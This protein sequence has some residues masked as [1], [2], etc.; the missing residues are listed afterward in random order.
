MRVLVSG[1]GGQLG[2]ELLELLSGSEHEAVGLTRR[3]LDISD[4][5]AVY[6]AVR[7]HSPGLIVNAAAFTDVDGCETERKLAYRVNALGPR[8]LAQVGE[9]SGCEL[10]HV[11]T[12]YVFSGEQAEPYEVF[13][14]P[15][16]AS[17]YGYTKLA[18]E[19]YVRSLCTRHYI[20]RSAGVYGRGKN[21]VRTMLRAA[22]ER[23]TL[24]VKGDEFISPTYARDLAEGIVRLI[25]DGLYG[26]Y[27]LTNAGSCS[28]QEFAQEIFRL[29]EME[30]EVLPVRTA[31]YPL[32]AARP[33]NGGL[34]SLGSP[35]LRPWRAALASYLASEGRGS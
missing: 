6:R 10:L 13:D 31:E 12:N 11:S 3:E 21:F 7:E 20:V 2:L 32:P 28:W 8:N 29:S 35:Q 25:D 14:A 4:P 9:R 27:H 17:V 23:D 22:G 1:A 26:V 16:P 19:E 5:A 33:A 34:S 30:V 18:G 24:R 15:A